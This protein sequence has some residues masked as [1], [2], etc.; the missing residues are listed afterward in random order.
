MSDRFE[1]VMELAKRLF[2]NGFATIPA[3]G[4]RPLVKISEWRERWR[5]GDVTWDEIETELIRWINR[6]NLNLMIL[7]GL[8]GIYAIDFDAKE[9]YQDFVETLPQNLRQKILRTLT[10]QT[11]RGY[12]V[13]LRCD[14]ENLRPTKIKVGETEWKGLGQQIN[15]PYSVYDDGMISKP[16]R[17]WN[18]NEIHVEEFTENELKIIWDI[19]GLSEE[20][21]IAELEF[22]EQVSLSDDQIDTIIDIIKEYY[23]EGHRDLIIFGLSGILARLKVRFEDAEKLVDKLT[24]KLEDEEKE[25]RLYVLKY[26][27]QR[28]RAGRIIPSFHTLMEI[29]GQA[30]AENA[31]KIVWRLRYIIIPEEMEI[32]VEL[33]KLR[34]NMWK[35]KGRRIRIKHVLIRKEGIYNRIERVTWICRECGNEIIL[36][37][38]EK[39]GKC[40]NCKSKDWE[41][42]EKR[43]KLRPI[44]LLRLVAENAEEIAVADA[45]E[46]NMEPDPNRK[47]DVVAKIRLGLKKNKIIPELWVVE[48]REPENEDDLNE[49]DV[50]KPNNLD[51]LM[52]KY[53][54][55][56]GEEK[57]RKLFLMA[58][59]AYQLRNPEY[60]IYGVVLQGPSSIGKS[61]F[62]N[63]M[64][65]ADERDG[66]IE[67]F[68][69]ITAGAPERMENFTLDGRIL[70]I[71][72]SFGMS[73]SSNLLKLMI[74]PEARGLRLLTVDKESGELQE[75]FVKGKPFLISATT[76]IEFRNEE[77]FNRILAL[78]LDASEDQTMRIKKYQADLMRKLPWEIDPNNERED[79]DLLKYWR[80]IRSREYYV[81]IP[82]ADLLAEKTENNIPMRRNFKKILG[83]IA[84]SAILL[85]H[86]RYK[87][88]LNGEEII[89]AD[90]EDLK[91]IID[92]QD[93]LLATSASLTRYEMRILEEIPEQ[94]EGE[95]GMSSAELAKKLPLSRNWIQK[96]LKKLFE[97]GYLIRERQGNEYRYWR[98]GNGA[99]GLGDV[100]LGAVKQSVEN[101]INLIKE[102]YGDAAIINPSTSTPSIHPK[103]EEL[104]HGKPEKPTSSDGVMMESTQKCV[105]TQKRVESTPSP[106]PEA[107]K[108]G[109]REARD[110]ISEWIN[111]LMAKAR[112]DIDKAILEILKEARGEAGIGSIILGLIDRGLI[113]KPESAEFWEVLKKDIARKCKC[114]DLVVTEHNI[115]KIPRRRKKIILEYEDRREIL[116]RKL[117]KEI[118][119][120]LDEGDYDVMIYFLNGEKEAEDLAW[121]K[122]LIPIRLNDDLD[123]I[124]RKEVKV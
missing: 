65:I 50:W 38:N 18:D 67:Y 23:R 115:V 122:G 81:V 108:I 2:D 71:A 22:L 33:A 106:S 86:K 52:R 105:D 95:M 54:K 116:V 89:I 92:L 57:S 1:R 118:I 96:C 45:N 68:T 72:E 53:D 69:R 16:I 80:W 56:V 66:N 83:L 100:D 87:I 61:Y 73:Q 58:R 41:I 26:I 76:E 114:L 47:Y 29:L 15:A 44:L 120:E 77:F 5:L 113:P 9:A 85:Q 35:L 20:I 46:L 24:D 11:R 40:A 93:L 19:L 74:D 28:A 60:K 27:Y 32:P 31:E 119:E 97:A 64:T 55:I 101:Y 4:K 99:R 21:R 36:N 78:N 10:V 39:P 43:T 62:I 123:E 104:S 79:D 103:A 3:E 6:E 49:E 121:R 75:Y 34:E 98:I 107:E 109:E 14:V 13:Y 59:A 7:T 91:N 25:Q 94:G 124:D 112:D 70:Y 117:T 12:H 30:G 102:K 42:D 90:E 8:N 88:R 82:Y 110:E 51:E 63:T 111:G 84:G 37:G 48:I 17:G